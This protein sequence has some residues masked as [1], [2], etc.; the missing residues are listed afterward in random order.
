MALMLRMVGIPARVVAGFSPGTLNR[1]SGE[2]RVRDLDAH[3]WV[4]VYFPGIG[5]VTFDPTPRASDSASGGAPAATGASPA[6]IVTQSSAGPE[7][8]LSEAGAQTRD[9][10]LEGGSVGQE[11]SESDSGGPASSVLIL[12]VGL[13]ALALAS[14]LVFA[15]R[16]RRRNALGREQLA[17][18]EI[19]EL[20]TALERLGW[21]LSPATTLLALERELATAAGPRAAAYAGALRRYRFDPQGSQPP[22]PADRRALRHAL[23]RASGPLGP[24]RALFAIPPG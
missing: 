12:A 7:Q 1:K 18:A 2:Y 19:A 13:A 23:G 14:A 20:R 5:W 9:S 21:K 4:E 10:Q 8:D 6:G 22:G 15:I 17:E 24:L 3:S 11:R 16:V